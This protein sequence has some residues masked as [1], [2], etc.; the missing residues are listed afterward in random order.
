MITED[1]Y[2]NLTQDLE[3]LSDEYAARASPRYA[4]P[5]KVNWQFRSRFAYMGSICPLGF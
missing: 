5:L 4:K 2:S 3:L 1:F